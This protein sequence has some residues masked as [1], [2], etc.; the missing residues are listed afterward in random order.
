MML[1]HHLRSHLQGLAIKRVD[2]GVIA[3]AILFA[4]TL[5]QGRH[6][7]GRIEHGEQ[8]RSENQRRDAGF[9]RPSAG[10]PWTND[11]VAIS[12]A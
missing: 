4:K 11:E 3:F 12:V 9:L 5:H 2:S 1:S 8:Q 6:F 10:G 7:A